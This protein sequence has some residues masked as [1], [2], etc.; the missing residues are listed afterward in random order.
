MC[1]LRSQIDHD[2]RILR[3]ENSSRIIEINLHFP[4]LAFFGSRQLLIH[5]VD[6]RLS[7]R[8]LLCSNSHQ[9]RSKLVITR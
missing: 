2:A 1:M 4:Y 8:I 7:E 6:I 5:L 9:Y 3:C